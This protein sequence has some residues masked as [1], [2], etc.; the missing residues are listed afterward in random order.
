VTAPTRALRAAAERMGNMVRNLDQVRI[1][2]EALEA[3]LRAVAQVE[4]A[5]THPRPPNGRDGDETERRRSGPWPGLWV[6]GAVAHA[7]GSAP[8]P[9]PVPI[10]QP[11]P[12]IMPQPAVTPAPVPQEPEVYHQATAWKM[13]R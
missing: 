2:G 6:A 7:L 10:P 4:V 9:Q 1:I 12:V 8:H 11:A 3:L 13:T 5:R